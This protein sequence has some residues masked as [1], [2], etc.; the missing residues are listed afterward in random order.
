MEKFSKIFFFI[1]LGL[2][3][4]ALALFS[5]IY[6]VNIQKKYLYPIK[7]YKEV[8]DSCKEF[9]ISP[10]LVFGVIKTESSFNEEAKSPKGAKGLMQIIDS[11]AEFIA[12]KLNSKEY[13]IYD[14]KTNIRFGC[15]YLRYL[16]DKFDSEELALCS[17]NA[18]EGRIREWL[19]DKR[20]SLDGKTLNKIPYKE[21]RNYMQRIYKNKLKYIKLYPN[22]LDK[23]IKF[24]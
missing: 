8:M 4:C 15:F 23:Q 18:G 22:L 11:T 10:Y 21:T 16:L 20:Y 7:N 13:D 17:Y 9:N 14:A 5:L 2:L 24:E 3:C 1:V 19:S 6:S 12:K